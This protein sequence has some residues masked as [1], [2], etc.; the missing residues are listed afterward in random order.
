MEATNAV[1]YLR[2]ML[3]LAGVGSPPIAESVAIR[4]LM[5]MSECL[6]VEKKGEWTFTY[7]SGVVGL[8]HPEIGHAVFKDGKRVCAGRVRDPIIP[9][10]DDSRKH[11]AVVLAKAREA[12]VPD[13]VKHLLPASVTED[14][15]GGAEIGP[16]S[17]V[18]QG[19]G[20]SQTINPGG[21]YNPPDG[22]SMAAKIVRKLTLMKQ[23]QVP[24]LA[25]TVM[26][27]LAIVRDNEAPVISTAD[28]GAGALQMAIDQK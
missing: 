14:A 13:A 19:T 10:E 21:P 7:G 20:T 6:S 8:S 12:G 23:Q 17:P 1:K 16:G 25:Q 5:V 22:V 18:L 24:P 27:S 26:N 28:P 4:T 9:D 15:P 11:A 2:S 3:D